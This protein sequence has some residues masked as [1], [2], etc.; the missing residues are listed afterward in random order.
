MKLILCRSCQDVYKLIR[1]EQR[2]CKCGKTAG[3]YLDNGIQAVISD[4]PETIPLGFANSE[5]KNAINQN[6]SQGP[7]A[8]G[9]GHRFAAFIIPANAANIIKAKTKTI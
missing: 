4:T 2:Q 3:Y 8:D 7:K 6:D 9:T 1:D 5:L